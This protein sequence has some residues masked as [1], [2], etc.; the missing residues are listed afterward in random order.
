MPILVGLSSSSVFPE[1][2]ERA[3]ELAAA[4]GYDGLELMVTADRMTQD[5]VGLRDLIQK[6]QIPVLSIHSPC[7]TISARVWGTDP[8][9][10]LERSLDLAAEIGAR[11]VVAHPPFAWQR[12]IAGHFPDQVEEL[13]KTVAEDTGVRIAIENMYPVTVLGRTVST[14]RP[15]WDVTVTGYPGYT[16]DLSHTAAAGVDAVEMA[17][18]MGGE[19]AHVH[20]G[21]GSGA[22]RDEHLVPGRGTARTAEVLRNLAGGRWGGAGTGA[23]IVEVSTRK[24]GPEEREADLAES[25]AFARKHLRP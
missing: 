24:S 25:L 17:R 19:L 16:L 18:E 21:D 6:H 11:T 13:A 15:D 4:L 5:P 22:A 8:V 9:G 23:V 14:Y 7:L 20:L 12:S 2:L 1:R 3:F 10:K